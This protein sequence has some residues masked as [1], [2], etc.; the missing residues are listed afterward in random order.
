MIAHSMPFSKIVSSDQGAREHYHVP[1][2]QREYTWGK[3]NWETLLQ[4]LAENDPG[5]FMGSLICVSDG[6]PASPGD[7][8]VFEVVDGQQRL[9]TLSLLM[10]AIYDRLTELQKAHT[11]DDEEDKADFQNALAS[12]RNKLVKRKKQGE[13]RKGEP[14][15]W[16]ESSRMCFL[17]VQPSSQNHNLEDYKHLLGEVGL[18]NK[19]ERP[20]YFHVRLMGRANRYFLEWLPQTVPD[21]LALVSKVNQLQFVHI[22]VSS[23]ADAFTL[24]ET[25]NNRG[26]P[27]S[28]IDIIKNKMLS[29]MER[30]H[31]VDIDASYD[32]WQGIVESVPDSAEQ[33]RF[34]RHVY[35]AFRW[36]PNIR[37]EGIPRANKSKLIAIYERLIKRGAQSIFE[38]LCDLAD[39]YGRLL[40]PVS[41]KFPKVQRA[42]LADLAR[43]NAAPAYQVLLYLFSQP[44]ESLAEEDFLSQA[45]DLLQR[46]YVRRNV[47]D[48]PNTRDLDQ[49]HMDLIQA[50]QE[51]ITSGKPLTF[52][53]FRTKL[54]ARGTYSTRKV[55]ET[56]LLG[57]M[58]ESNVL[59]T[60]Y[61]LVKLDET[62]HTREYKPDLWAR[63][64]GDKFVW[65]VEHVLPQTEKIPKEWMKMIAGG[66]AERAAA[67]HEQH[68]DRLGNLTL[69]GYNSKLATAS[70]EKKQALSEGRTFLGH[71]IDIGYRNGLA[72]NKLTF[73]NGT[74]KTS[75]A[76][77][78]EWTAEMIEARTRVMVETLLKMYEFE[79][80]D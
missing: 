66:D 38:R 56:A 71:S 14:G 72:L 49:A 68:V 62:H 11:F 22:S 8:T 27:L 79:G 31:Q 24:F 6:E 2:Y 59:M 36:D 51:R 75:L 16:L 70:F 3:G 42:Q 47:T 48:F 45:A 19:T 7:E 41:S 67:I 53:F 25:L 37:V 77:A 43:T 69:S 73:P 5:Y 33:E 74:R 26:V 29:E 4:D 60:R 20:P 30:Q 61:L 39:L 55:F 34:L 63:S 40:S 52:Q 54:L 12:L 80:V 57:P 44:A 1:K 21:L 76:T 35:N 13:F 9:T 46:Y 65:T 18:I 17:R 32:R 64:E 28:A 10:I 78:D 15:G 58:Y 23:Q 50:C